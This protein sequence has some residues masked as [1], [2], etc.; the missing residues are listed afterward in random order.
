MALAT[1]TS[2][3]QPQQPDKDGEKHAR[4]RTNSS[5]VMIQIIESRLL[6]EIRPYTGL[7]TTPAKAIL[8]NS[9]SL[10]AKQ[11]TK[12]KAC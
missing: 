12:H 3:N 9:L 7:S 6:I 8:P 1:I 10:K 4:K 2:H 5:Q 11:Q